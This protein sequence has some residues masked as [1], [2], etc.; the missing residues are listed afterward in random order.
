MIICAIESLNKKTKNQIR[1]MEYI[2]KSQFLRVRMFDCCAARNSRSLAP[3]I[4][5][6][7]PYEVVT[8]TMDTLVII[9]VLMEQSVY[10]YLN[11]VF[12]T[13]HPIVRQIPTSSDFV[14]ENVTT[15]NHQP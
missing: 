7:S 15:G 14:P 13:V 10:Y 11:V 12:L 3:H 5:L 4:R 1:K 8:L 6:P 9:Q 2:S